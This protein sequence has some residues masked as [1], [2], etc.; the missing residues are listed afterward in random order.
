MTVDHLVLLD[1]IAARERREGS[2]LDGSM[3]LSEAHP[4]A[5]DDI[6]P[7]AALAHAFDLLCKMNVLVWRPGSGDEKRSISGSIDQA[8]LGA[9]K[10]IRVNSTGHLLCNASKSPQQIQ[11]N[12]F[13]SSSVGQLGMGDNTVGD[14]RVLLAAAQEELERLDADDDLKAEAREKLGRLQETAATIGTSAVASLI[15]AALQSAIGLK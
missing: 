1:W 5:G 3:L 12:I 9:L 4:L 15:T 14:V 2:E 11:V 13:N 7:W 10:G 8:A 6:E